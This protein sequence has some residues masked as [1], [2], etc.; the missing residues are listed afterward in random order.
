LPT[1]D[2]DFPDYYFATAYYSISIC[3]TSRLKT[4]RPSNTLSPA[5]SSSTSSMPSLIISQGS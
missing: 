4:Q 1:Y 2:Y 3:Y 5:L